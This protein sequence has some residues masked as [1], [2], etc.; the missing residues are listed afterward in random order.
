MAKKWTVIFQ[1]EHFVAVDKPALVLTTPPRF[2]DDRPV[3]GRELEKQLKGQIWPVHRLDFEVSGLVLFARSAP[4]H[5]EASDWFERHQVKKTYQAY[6][7]VLP[8]HQADELT[9]NR[10]WQSRLLRGKKRTYEHKTGKK[11]TTYARVIERQV[12][13]HEN[14]LKWALNPQT[15]RPHQLRYELSHRG[16][17]ILG[18]ALYSSTMPWGDG[19]GL[20]AI[21]IEFLKGCT[22]TEKWGVPSLIKASPLEFTKPKGAG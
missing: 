5:R 19:I 7:E 13:G 15:G 8:S 4:A 20:R 14:I 11:A 3:L 22:A 9:G 1:N 16:F 21:E 2:A 6:T 17:P 10:F 12:A 18:D